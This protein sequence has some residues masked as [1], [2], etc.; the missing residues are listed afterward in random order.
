[1]RETLNPG[2]EPEMLLVADEQ[3]GESI[4]LGQC[5]LGG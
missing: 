4:E 3:V 5:F 1:M 2:E